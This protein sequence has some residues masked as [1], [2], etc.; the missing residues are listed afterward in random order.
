[1]YF[2]QQQRSDSNDLVFKCCILHKIIARIAQVVEFPDFSP[3]GMSVHF[4]PCRKAKIMTP[5]KILTVGNTRSLVVEKS[6]VSSGVRIPVVQPV[7][8]CCTDRAILA[9]VLI[10]LKL[11]NT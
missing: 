8:R 3:S 6:F 7:V 4:I 2:T 1:L 5:G 10:V 9:V 11:L